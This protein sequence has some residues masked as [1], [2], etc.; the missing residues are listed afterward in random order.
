M[1]TRKQQIT[2][3]RKVSDVEG[4]EQVLHE[5][6]IF[7]REQIVEETEN[8]RIQPARPAVASDTDEAAR[9]N[10]IALMRE[11]QR[12]RRQKMSAQ[13]D[14]NQQSDIMKKFEENLL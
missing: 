14:M 2:R 9:Q 11:Q 5:T 6:L 3:K 10:K 12:L 4:L 1:E 7:D 13:I 8:T